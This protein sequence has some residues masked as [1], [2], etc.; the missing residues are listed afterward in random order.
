MCLKLFLKHFK[1]L[2]D[3]TKVDHRDGRRVSCHAG[4]A[5]WIAA[6]VWVP[7]SDPRGSVG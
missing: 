7:V 2:P 6:C 4:H 5:A 1:L 3:D